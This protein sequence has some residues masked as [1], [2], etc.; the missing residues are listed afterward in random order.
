MN[1]ITLGL[2][3]SSDE[4]FD[5][6]QGKNPHR[7]I[8]QYFKDPN[9]GLYDP[10]LVLN[11]LKNLDKMEPKNR[12]QWLQFEKAIK[13]DRQMTKF[14]N[15]V[16]KGL[17]CSESFPEEGLYRPDKID[18]DSA[19]S[20]LRSSTSPTVLP[21]LPMQTFRCSTIR[22]KAIS[23]PMNLPPTSTMFSSTSAFS[24]RP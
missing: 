19:M 12:T 17:L 7:Y 24:D 4:L 8:L 9:T 20:H 11:Y 18:Q 16:T 22:I 3:V 13:D 23:M 14:N 6:V 21:N 5:Q 15:L 10:A 1:T 2:T